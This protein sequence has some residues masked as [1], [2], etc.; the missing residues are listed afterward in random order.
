MFT[1]GKGSQY[2]TDPEMERLPL[3]NGF[4]EKDLARLKKAAERYNDKNYGLHEQ[5]VNLSKNFIITL[6]IGIAAVA[7]PVLDILTNDAFDIGNMIFMLAIIFIILIS[8]NISSPLKL[9]LKSYL[10]MKKAR[11]K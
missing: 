5:I 11:G 3:K 10:F 7:F 9:S 8:I 1:N 4:T 2:M 6:L